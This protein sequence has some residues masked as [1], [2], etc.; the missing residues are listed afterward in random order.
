MHRIFGKQEKE[1][2][3]CRPGAYLIPVNNGKVAVAYV[4][5]RHYL[6]GG[7]IEGDETQEECIRRECLEEAGCSCEIEGFLCSAE[8]YVLNEEKKQHHYPQYYYVGKLLEKCSEP[9][10]RDHELVWI[11]IEELRGKMHLE[12]QNWALEQCWEKI[13]DDTV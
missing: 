4:F 1:V 10:E 5:G 6:L 13:K 3:F 8:W 9:T 7:G 2:F 11:P 12:M